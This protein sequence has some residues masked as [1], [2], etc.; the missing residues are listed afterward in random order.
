[1]EPYV[2]PLSLVSLPFYLSAYPLHALP[3]LERN[4]HPDSDAGT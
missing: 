1:M 4:V 2:K 3:L